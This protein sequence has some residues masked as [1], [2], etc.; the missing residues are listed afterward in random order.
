MIK[1]NSLRK[2]YNKASRNA[3]TAVNGI[4]LE[5]PKT[6]MVALFG[7]SGCGKTTL[8]NLIGGLDRADSG[9]VSLGDKII[10][11]DETDARNRNIG[12]ILQN[13]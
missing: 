12:F 2:T 5:L 8:L 1:L 7:R 4:S 11:P 9:S 10:T 13:Y 3:V 6:G